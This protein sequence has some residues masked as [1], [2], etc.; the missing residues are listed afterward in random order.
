MPVLFERFWI[1]ERLAVLYVPAV[2]DVADRQFDHL[3]AL[4]AR[5]VG[6]L[7]DLCRDVA[8]RG[9]L[10]DA[11]AD[12]VLQLVGECRAVAEL[13]EEHDAFVVVPLLADHDAFHDLI[14][15]FDLTVDLRGTDAN[16]AGIQDGVGAAVNDHAAVFRELDPVAMAPDARV[17]PEIGRVVLPA[18]RVVPEADRHRG[19]R[20]GADQLPFLADHRASVLVEDLD[21]HAEGAALNL[22][23]P[24]RSD[25]IA[26]DK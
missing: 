11:A 3:A 6:D 14:E 25:G 22:A 13:H 10:T 20:Q 19:E 8:R 18:V 7:Q 26:T 16:A 9:V 15:L 5:H 1:R 24:D 21:L 4:R 17:G 12:A 2:D 23:T